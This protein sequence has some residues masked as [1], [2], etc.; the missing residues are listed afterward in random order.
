MAKISSWNFVNPHDDESAI[1]NA[2]A[3]YGPIV[4]AIYFDGSNLN[5]T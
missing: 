5:Y 2:L 4:V 3:L 1:A